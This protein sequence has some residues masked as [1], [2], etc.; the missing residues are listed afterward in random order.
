MKAKVNWI[1]KFQLEG[2]TATGHTITMDSK[3]AGNHSKGPTPKELILQAVA[4][5]T[6]MDVVLIIE[7][8]RKLLD[9]FWVDI[10]AELA[11]EH[12]K[13]FTKIHLTYNFIS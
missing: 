13:T 5:C 8:S 2:E 3:P 10:D 1:N 4:G 6:M 7:K 12:P 9:K 11:P